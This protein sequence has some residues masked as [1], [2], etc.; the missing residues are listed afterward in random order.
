MKMLSELEVHGAKRSIGFKVPGLD[1]NRLI[2]Q[3]NQ[4]KEMLK[5]DIRSLSSNQVELIERIVDEAGE[6]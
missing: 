1:K 2:N 5:G 3:I 4:I 6:S